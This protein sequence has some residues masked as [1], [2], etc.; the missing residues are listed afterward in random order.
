[1]SIS[2][3]IS[4]SCENPI[5]KSIKGHECGEGDG[6]ALSSDQSGLLDRPGQAPLVQNSNS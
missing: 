3:V 5:V 6:R 2:V 1:M 4:S